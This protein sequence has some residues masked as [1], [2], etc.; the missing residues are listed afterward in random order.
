[1]FTFFFFFTLKKIGEKESEVSCVCVYFSCSKF[2]LHFYSWFRYTSFSPQK[3]KKKESQKKKPP[4][5]KECFILILPPSFPLFCFFF[6]FLISVGNKSYTHLIY[7][8]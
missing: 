3:K 5:L 2:R 6:L 7:F 1:M 8:R 4:S